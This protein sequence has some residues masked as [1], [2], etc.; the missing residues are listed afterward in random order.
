MAHH[1]RIRSASDPW[2]N[3]LPVELGLFE[4]GL[5][6]CINAGDGTGA[7]G[8]STHAPT[9]PIIVLGPN[10]LKITGPT[11]VAYGGQLATCQDS[12]AVA[13]PTV[14]LQDGDWPLLDPSNSNATKLRY[15]P[16][17]L[18]VGIPSF[19][20]VVRQEVAGLQAIAPS[21]DLSD[22]NG[23]Q[24][25]RAYQRLRAHDKSTI[26]S[27]TVYF[28]VS[29]LHTNLPTVMP[30]VRVLRVDA[31]GNSAVLTSKASGA[32]INGFVYVPAPASPTAWT[33]GFAQ[34]TLVVPCD[35]NNVVDAGNFSYIVEL[36]E[37][38]GLTGWPW[39]VTFTPP[40]VLASYDTDIGSPPHA[41][42]SV[43]SQWDGNGLLPGAGDPVLV[44]DQ[45][46]PNQNG[47]YIVGAG[48]WTRI[49]ITFTQGFIVPVLGGASFQQGTLWQAV[50]TITQWNPTVIGTANSPNPIYFVPQSDNS[51]PQDSQFL[52][53]HGILWQALLVQYSA[54]PD[55]RPD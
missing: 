30:S 48:N 31:F 16:C 15:E 42:P 40:V 38:Q 54:I 8:G 44:K 22:G 39:Q 29:T 27:V 24:P 10:G 25:A 6:A 46:D 26:S 20:F 53:A 13:A 19:T 17:A 51:F 50:S 5:A 32:D 45:Q 11:Q 28:H 18:A 49:P 4:Q 47:L 55:M 2:A 14:N 12:T 7:D 35:Q 9:N 43:T 3:I 1:A 37:E 41:L 23:Q 52:V 33:N 34:Q 21:F 36:V